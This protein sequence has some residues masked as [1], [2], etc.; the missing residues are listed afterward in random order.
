[1]SVTI[2]YVLDT[3]RAKGDKSYPLV[4]RFAINRNTNQVSTGFTLLISEW[5]QKNQQVKPKSRSIDITSS[6]L[7][8]LLETKYVS[9]REYFADLVEKDAL[10]LTPVSVMKEKVKSIFQGSKVQTVDTFDFI[11]QQ[12]KITLEANQ[13]GSY[14]VMKGLLNSLKNYSNIDNLPFSSIDYSFL[15]GYETK[16]FSRGSKQGSLSVYMRA[17]RSIYNKAI[18][19][20]LVDEKHYPFSSY[21]IKSGTSEKRALTKEDFIKLMNVELKENSALGIARN[22]YLASFMLRG[23]NWIDLCNLKRKNFTKDWKR[24]SYV[25]KKTKKPFNLSVFPE[26]IEVILS[27]RKQKNISDDDYVF[28][29]IDDTL[30]EIEKSI[31]IM[32]RRKKINIYLKSLAD[33]LS[34][35]RFTIYSARHTWATLGKFNGM[36][37]A[38]IQESLGHSTEEMTQTYLNSFGNEEVDLHANKLFESLREST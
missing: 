19:H 13:I 14:K 26:L 24:V 5:D 11:N 20:G 31:K 6:K 2:K 17:L 15:K 18:K 35:D 36:P 22:Y 30:S 21:K 10:T 28:P 29:V 8:H 32:N 37:T 9:I 16:H 7:N 3:R 34:I 1:M 23:M 27:L 38:V 12:M 33:H 4:I 25:R